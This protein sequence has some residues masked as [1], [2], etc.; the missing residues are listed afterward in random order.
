MP[1]AEP[2][3]RW[4]LDSEQNSTCRRKLRHQGQSFEESNWCWAGFKRVCHA[5][6]KDHFSWNDFWSMAAEHHYLRPS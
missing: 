4:R 2:L 5:H 3:R 6:L 1:V